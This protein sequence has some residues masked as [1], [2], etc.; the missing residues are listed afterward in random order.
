MRTV[1]LFLCIVFFWTCNENPTGSYA[2]HKQTYFDSLENK[3]I[4]LLNS[5]NLSQLNDTAKWLLYTIHCDDSCTEGRAKYEQF[6]EKNALSFLKLNLNYVAKKGD[7]LSL[8]Y[9]FLYR[10]SI[11]I[12][13]ISRNK[14]ITNGILFNVRDKKIIGYVIGEATYSESGNPNSRYENSLQPEV[15][16]FIKSNMDKLNPWF[17]KEA[18]RRKILE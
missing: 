18:K 9:S 8:L 12:E 13:K 4:E 17:R 2:T 3:N 6:I 10:D 1:L 11:T 7:T 15:I 16:A 5:Y 14:G